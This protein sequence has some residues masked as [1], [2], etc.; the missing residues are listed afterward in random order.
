MLQKVIERLME[1]TGTV[2]REMEANFFHKNRSS[3]GYF[4]CEPV[5]G[6]WYLHHDGKVKR[7][8]IGDSAKPAFWETEEAANE[9]FN[10]WKARRKS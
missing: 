7:G 6:I 8:V 3:R 9:F 2:K 10:N 1:K 4:I 5:N